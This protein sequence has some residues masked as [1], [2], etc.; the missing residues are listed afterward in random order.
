MSTSLAWFFFIRC[1]SVRMV[2]GRVHDFYMSAIACVSLR[3]PQPRFCW[4]RYCAIAN[5]ETHRCRRCRSSIVYFWT[6]SHELDRTCTF[7]RARID[8]GWRLTP[9]Q[10]WWDVARSRWKRSKRWRGKTADIV[11]CHWLVDCT[12]CRKQ[13]QDGRCNV[14]CCHYYFKTS[15]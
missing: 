12:C 10:R 13:I 4:S 2:F 7:F 14:Q 6:R 5:V 1:C 15:A 9:W 8:A 3:T 11:S